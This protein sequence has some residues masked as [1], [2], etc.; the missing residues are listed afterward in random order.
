MTWPTLDYEDRAWVSTIDPGHLSVY[1]RLRTSRPYRAAVVPRIADEAVRVGPAAT[2][3]SEAATQD[4]VRFDE[5]MAA[6]P[7][8]MPAVLLRTESA[9][10]SQ[11]EHLTTNTRNLA[12]ASIGIDSKQN[13]ELVAANV[14]AMTLAFEAGAQRVDAASLLAVHRALLGGSEPDVAG[15]WRTE[16]VWIGSHAAYPHGADFIPPH[17]E[18][19]PDAIDDLVT[20]AGRTDL[21]PL[22][23]AAIAHAQFET[24]HPFTDGN[25]RTGRV[26]LQSLLRHRGLVR[27]ATTPVSAGLL[28]D[29]DRYFRAL[30]A[31]RE[32]DVDDIVH[33]VAQAA[34]TA[35]ANGRELA[36]HI[37]EIRTRWR[38]QITARS[39]SSAWA[40]SDALFAQPVVT[41]E[42]VSRTLGLSDRGARNTIDVLVRDGVLTPATSAKRMQ[43]WQAP[44]VLTAMDEFARRAGRRR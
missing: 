36:A 28:R 21:P 8:P 37:T 39:N 19:V 27:H 25:G 14:R 17:H 44:E 30:T 10:S 23:Q 9:S 32:G 38:E 35:A 1:E 4:V 16:Q 2:E 29:P 31:Y 3:I 40:L 5:Q 18:R 22:V 33:Q 12:M 6:L 15:R 20:F 11:I 13:A 24:I 26:L 41:A 43:Y 42:H 34:M 7:V